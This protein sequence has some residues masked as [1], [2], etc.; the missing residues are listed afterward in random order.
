MT[1]VSQPSLTSTMQQR[2][3]ALRKHLG[4]VVALGILEIVA[5]VFAVSYAFGSTVVSVATLGMLF[6]V[7]AVAQVAA[8]IVAPTWRGFSLS[9]LLGML[10]GATGVYSLADPIAAAES[11]TLML[12]FLFLPAVLSASPSHC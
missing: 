6:L 7:A 11:L 2:A 3:A 8:A 9:L 1:S 5:G 4:W 12:A 10:Y